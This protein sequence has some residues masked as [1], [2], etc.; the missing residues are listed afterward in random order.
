MKTDGGATTVLQLMISFLLV[1]ITASGVVGD[2]KEPVLDFRG[3]LVATNV[4][5]FLESSLGTEESGL[6][7][8]SER[9]HACGKNEKITT[10]I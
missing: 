10:N 3:R 2:Q 7:V 5:Y 4:R 9:I 1:A 8:S 6:T